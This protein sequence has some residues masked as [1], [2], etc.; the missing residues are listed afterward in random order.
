MSS[1]FVSRSETKDLYV[2]A[3]NLASQ[4][5]VVLVSQYDI[6]ACV[7]NHNVCVCVCQITLV[8]ESDLELALVAGQY[9]TEVKT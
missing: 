2:K 3:V 8:Q 4:Q 5:I 1:H 6:N 7:D 9:I